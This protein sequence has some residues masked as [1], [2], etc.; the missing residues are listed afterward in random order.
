MLRTSKKIIFTG[1]TVIGENVVCTYSA[2]IDAAAPEKTTIGRFKK[3]EE[4]YNANR[5]ECRADFA[6][7]E[8][9]VIA[10]QVELLK[11]ES[12]TDEQS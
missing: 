1:E 7:F 3:D 10:A 9:A 11:S 8:D 4:A 6:A 5:A 2:T 12:V